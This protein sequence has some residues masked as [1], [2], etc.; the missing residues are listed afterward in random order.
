MTM[1]TYLGVKVVQ[2]E[3][4][5][6]GEY[7]ASRG[8]T[9][10]ADENPEDD[11]YRILYPDGYVSWSP[12]QQFVDA[13]R[14]FDGSM[15]FG[16]AIEAMRKGM[17]VTR[18]GWNGRSMWLTLS[19]GGVVSHDKFWAARNAEF[20]LAQGGVAEVRPYVTMKTADDCIV[21]WVASQTDILAEDWEVV[22]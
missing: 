20:A 7:N 13:Y 18:L 15:T 2:A 3:P 8:W 21:P 12:R 9:V 6:R 4:Q 5:T 14:S 19:P 11:G 17:R 16:H 1:K 22:S 10:P